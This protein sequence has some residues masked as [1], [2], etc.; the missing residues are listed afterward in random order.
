MYIA[1]ESANK[2]KQMLISHAKCQT[3]NIYEY[4]RNMKNEHKINKLRQFMKPENN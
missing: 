4:T 2:T 3:L 1:K